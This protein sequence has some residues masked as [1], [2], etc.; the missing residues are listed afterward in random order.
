LDI[1]G[2]WKARSSHWEDHVHHIE[3]EE[4]SDETF[5]PALPEESGVYFNFD[6]CIHKAMLPE[7]ADQT[8]QAP[9]ALRCSLLLG[10]S[11]KSNQ[12]E[13]EEAA[14]IYWDQ[15]VEFK[16]FPSVFD[17]TAI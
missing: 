11:C 17:S 4:V 7:G 12:G 13:M 6:G 8:A 15:P 16:S 9:G 10:Y 1:V 2:A 5:H 3:C 14:T